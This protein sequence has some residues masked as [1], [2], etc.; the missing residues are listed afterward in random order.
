MRR[1]IVYGVHGYGRGHA[2]RALAVLPMLTE[3]Y[4]VR[5][6]A[7]D[8]AYD[9]LHDEYPVVRIPTLR[10]Y[11]GRTGRRSPWQTIKRNTPGV[12]DLLLRGP[13]ANL[14]EAELRQF[15]PDVVLSDS[16]G[17]THHAARRLGIPRI[18]FDHYGVMAYCRLPMSRWDRLV[19]KS[20]SLFYR[21]LVAGPER[22]IV[23]AFFPAEPNRP[24]VRVVGPILRKEVCDLQPTDGEHLLVYFTNAREHY[25]PDVEAALLT[26]DC[27]VKVFTHEK[28]GTVK[29]IEYCPIANRPFVETLASCRAVF[30][31]AGNQL[32]SEAIHLAK[33]LLVTPEEALEQRLNAQTVH[34]WKIGLQASHKQIGP[35]LL[36]RFLTRND[37]FAANIAS[38]RRDGLAEAWQAIQQAI[39]ELTP[40]PNRQENQNE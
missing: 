39:E 36:Q 5:I 34:R 22:V 38:H 10:Y 7:G 15:A 2:A 29:N 11:A 26:L 28:T 13:G 23:A 8:D 32:I 30:S 1:K 4:D 20:E 31:T 6:L 33:P 9:Q 14:V 18:S 35:D 19:C 40:S 25:T 21:G 24:G 12:L 37:E 16:E 3:H 17:W 27:P